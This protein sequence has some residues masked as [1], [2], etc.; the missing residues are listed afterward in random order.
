MWITFVTRKFGNVERNSHCDVLHIAPVRVANLVLD[1]NGVF[2]IKAYGP[3]LMH[4][5]N[6]SNGPCLNAPGKPT[7]KPIQW[8]LCWCSKE[9]PPPIQWPSSVHRLM[10]A[11]V[12]LI[13]SHEF[14][15]SC[16]AQC[17]IDI[18]MACTYSVHTAIRW[19]VLAGLGRASDFPFQ[20]KQF[21]V[22]KKVKFRF[23]S[24]SLLA[25]LNSMKSQYIERK[26]GERTV[27][28]A[29]LV[30]WTEEK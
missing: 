18:L 1:C 22:S 6:P 10:F 19:V 16:S 29:Q 13:I 2:A 17:V 20:K 11:A 26:C 24:V 3:V 21:S 30:R 5:G 8:S 12:L 4:R 28:M 27:K 9:T 25:T 7:Q 15:I 23:D 14:T